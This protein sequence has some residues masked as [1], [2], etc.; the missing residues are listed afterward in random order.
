MPLPCA[1]LAAPLTPE[2]LAAWARDGYL[3]VENFWNADTVGALKA[4]SDALL[5]SFDPP[6]SASVFSTAEQARTSD[7]YFLSSGDAVRFFFE[8]GAVDAAGRLAVAK[9]V[10]V[11]KIGHALHAR[12]P[13]FRAVSLECARVAAVARALGFAA[14][15]VP[16]SMLICKP[17]KIGGAVGPHVDGAF[18]YTAPQSCVGFWWPL[19]DCNLENGCLWAVPGSHARGGGAVARR[20][21]RAAA[22]GTEFVPADAAAADLGTDGAV[23]LL[24]PAGSLVLLHHN[25]VHFSERNKSDGSRFAYSIHVVEGGASWPADNWLQIDGA[26]PPLAALPALAAPAE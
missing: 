21:R 11:N 18:L 24:T 8:P 1:D 13:A 16:Q 20:F 2:Q 4:A 23:P 26:F 25:V 5:A 12:V 6:A 10:A 22:G 15:V 19:E 17:A 3:V 14:P 7:E 9:E